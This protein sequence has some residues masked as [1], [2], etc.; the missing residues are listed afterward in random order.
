MQTI[1]ANISLWKCIPECKREQVTKYKIQQLENIPKIST[2]Q[3][4]GD[5]IIIHKNGYIIEIKNICGIPKL[6]LYYTKKLLEGTLLREFGLSEHIDKL[7]I[8]TSVYLILTLHSIYKEG[9]NFY[10][11]KDNYNNLDLSDCIEIEMK[12]NKKVELYHIPFKV[13]RLKNAR[14]IL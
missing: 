6:T 4:D 5:E 11:T 7:S 3:L 9:T 10:T 8:A 2:I 12:N 1:H 14:S 13:Q